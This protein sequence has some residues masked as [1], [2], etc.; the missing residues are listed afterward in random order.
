[1]KSAF[2]SVLLA[3]VLTA[4]PPALADG[5][6]PSAS[7]IKRAADAFDRGRE[8]FRADAYVE[9]A[10]HFEAA[11]GYAPSAL[12]LRFALASRHEAGQLARAATLASLA[13]ARHPEDAELQELAESVLEEASGVLYRVQVFCDEPCELVLNDKIVHG[14]RANERVIFVEP[15]RHRLRA[16]WPQDRNRSEIIEAT[17]GGSG[18]VDFYVPDAP[19]DTSAGDWELGT[20]D[21]GV[22]IERSGWSPVVFWTSLGVTVAGG[23]ASTFL[24]LR[25]LNEPGREAVR[26]SC[27]DFTGTP[28]DCPAYKEGRSHQTQANVAIAATSAVGVFTIITGLFLTDWESSDTAADSAKS[29]RG[30]SRGSVADSGVRVKPWFGVGQTT[31][32]GAMGTF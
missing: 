29:R 12:A 15:G 31:T 21:S 10:E 4:A 32:I 1:M 5:S 28:T 25:A 18:E 23:A 30:G 7:H 13:V 8:A 9:A 24:G 27:R 2:Q 16:S 3:L 22:N 19:S 14:R 11:D 17:A 20:S 6:A 26:D